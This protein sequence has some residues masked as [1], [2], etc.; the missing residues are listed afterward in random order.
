MSD[1]PEIVDNNDALEPRKRSILPWIGAV[2]GVLGA[3]VLAWWVGYQVGKDVGS[4]DIKRLNRELNNCEK[5]SYSLGVERDSLRRSSKP[6]TSLL[7]SDDADV[8]FDGGIIVTLHRVRVSGP[9][10]ERW[11]YLQVSDIGSGKDTYFST[12]GKERS[13]EFEHND[14]KCI[15]YFLGFEEIKGDTCVRIS[16]RRK[17]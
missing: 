12:S 6:D 16:V 13:Y 2:G 10:D 17:E 1:K 8:F 14:Q 11:A 9:F 3:V 7:C 5:Q 4:E 15:L